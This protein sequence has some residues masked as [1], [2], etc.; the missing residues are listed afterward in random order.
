M[1]GLFGFNVFG[2]GFITS[3]G[4]IF[5]TGVFVSSWLGNS[6]LALASLIITKA[7]PA[8]RPPDASAPRHAARGPEISLN[9]SRPCALSHSASDSSTGELGG[10]NGSL[11]M[12]R[13]LQ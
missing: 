1:Q 6:L 9:G 3:M 10:V 5:L 2:L 8:A 11:P 7:R 4:F 13:V 12:N